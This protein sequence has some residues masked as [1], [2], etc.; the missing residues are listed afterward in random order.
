MIGFIDI[1]AQCE[2]GN[3]NRSNRLKDVSLPTSVNGLLQIFSLVHR[4][5]P[6]HQGNLRKDK[7][8]D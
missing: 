3:G 1:K 6:V 7:N 8:V 5:A 2:V 4:R